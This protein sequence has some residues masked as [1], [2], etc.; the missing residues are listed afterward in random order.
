MKLNL[1]LIIEPDTLLTV[2]GNPA[3]MIVDLCAPQNWQQLHI[4]G[5]VHINPSELVLGLPPAPGLLPPVEKL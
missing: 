4:H 1:D 5:A 3:L 2:L